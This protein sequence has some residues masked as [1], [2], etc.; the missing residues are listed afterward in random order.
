MIG[1]G[2]IGSAEEESSSISGPSSQKKVEGETRISASD[3]GGSCQESERQEG[4]IKRKDEGQ[5]G[6]VPTKLLI[7]SEACRCR[8]NMKF[9]LD[10]Q[11]S[12]FGR[13]VW[14]MQMQ[15]PKSRAQ[16]AGYALNLQ[17]ERICL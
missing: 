10:V 4:Q 6:Q 16:Q 5:L 17:K 14:A 2:C 7:F 3:A 1:Q 9:P 13:A 12:G 8:A 11:D 15:T